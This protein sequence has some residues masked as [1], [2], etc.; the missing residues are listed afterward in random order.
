M[1]CPPCHPGQLPQFAFWCLLGQGQEQ[2]QKLTD[3]MGG[4]LLNATI[5]SL[6]S[7]LA[8]CVRLPSLLGTRRNGLEVSG[9][10]LT[11]KEGS[12]RLASWPWGAGEAT[13]VGAQV[14]LHKVKPVYA[15]RGNASFDK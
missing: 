3:A 11:W 15:F 8:L 4:L 10:F 7:L 5:I 2:L 12:S 14:L 9:Q 1:N 6:K 13:S